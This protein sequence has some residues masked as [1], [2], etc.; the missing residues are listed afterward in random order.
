MTRVEHLEWCKTRALKY[1]EA[2]DPEMAF[3]SM[4]SDLRKHTDTRHHA[5]AELGML[6]MMSGLFRSSRDMRAWIE[7]FN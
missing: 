2:G 5:G 1:V 4:V 7:G 3:A 6:Y